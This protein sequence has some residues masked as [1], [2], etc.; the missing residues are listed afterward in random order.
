MPSY[1]K[2]KVEII[3]NSNTLRLLPLTFGD[4]FFHKILHA[5]RSRNTQFHANLTAML[6]L[7]FLA[8]FLFVVI[9]DTHLSALCFSILTFWKPLGEP[10][11]I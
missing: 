7:T 8:S 11:W 4:L 6:F 10:V 9:N 2:R 1:I 3:W 5:Y